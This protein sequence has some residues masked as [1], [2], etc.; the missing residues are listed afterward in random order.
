MH[1]IFK[2]LFVVT[3]LFFIQSTSANQIDFYWEKDMSL[4]IYND[5][6]INKINDSLENFYNNTGLNTDIVILWKWDECYLESNFDSCV[7]EK[8]NYSSDL[9][10]VFSMKSDIKSGW[11][12]RTLIKDEFKE[13]LTPRD[14]KNMQDQIIPNLKNNQFTLWINNYLTYIWNFINNKCLEI[15]LEKSCSA[16]ELA[17]EYHSFVAEKEYQKKYNAMIKIIY[18]FIF[19][20]LMVLTY[21][22]FKRYY[23]KSIN[24]LYKDIKYKITNI[25]EY[26]IF[27]K[28]RDNILTELNSLRMV[29]KNKLWDLDKNTFSLRKTYKSFSM[30]LSKIEEELSSMQSS[31]TQKEELKDKVEKM[32]NIDL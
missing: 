18:Y 22:F 8:Y 17:R 15:G 9:I 4:D 31:F 29:V 11:D 6:N 16:V 26:K 27:E 14:F 30:D 13:V 5:E 28:D 24:N 32:K 23:I 25:W 3:L 19:F 10:I 7:Q 2:I 1:K 12:T 20:V 21:K